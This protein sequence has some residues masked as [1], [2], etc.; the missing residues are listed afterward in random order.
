MSV[1]VIEEFEIVDI[2]HQEGKRLVWMLLDP[3]FQ[4]RFKAGTI[5]DLGQGIDRCFELQSLDL[6]EIPDEHEKQGFNNNHERQDPKNFLASSPAG[7]RRYFQLP[8]VLL[9]IAGESDLDWLRQF[10]L[11]LGNHAV[12]LGQRSQL[13][14]QAVVIAILA[15]GGAGLFE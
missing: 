12:L 10:S 2:N 14:G 13:L 3:A 8:F 15:H 9:V 6:E 1:I 5:V 11:A 7:F 4:S